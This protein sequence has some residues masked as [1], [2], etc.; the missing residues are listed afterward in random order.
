MRRKPKMWDGPDANVDRPQVDHPANVVRFVLRAQS[1]SRPRPL[2]GAR[3]ARNRRIILSAA[4]RGG[5]PPLSHLPAFPATYT[6]SLS[7]R[8]SSRNP[9]D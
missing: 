7:M 2:G 3:V 4:S 6:C 8:M 9:D 1:R 5:H